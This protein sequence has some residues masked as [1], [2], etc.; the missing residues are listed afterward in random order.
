[1]MAPIATSAACWSCSGRQRPSSTRGSPIRISVVPW[2]RPQAKPMRAALLAFLRFSEAIR[3]VTAARWSGSEA[4]LK[5]SS[6]LT[7]STTHN[8]S[9]PCMKPSSQL[10]IADMALLLTILAPDTQ[11]R[12]GRCRAQPIAST[13]C[14]GIRRLVDDTH[15]LISRSWLNHKRVHLTQI[16]LCYY[17]TVL[18]RGKEVWALK[19]W[20]LVATSRDHAA[21][22]IRRVSSSVC[23]VKGA[24]RGAQVRASGGPAGIQGGLGRLVQRGRSWGSLRREEKGCTYRRY[25]G[26]RDNLCSSR[27]LV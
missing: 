2:P 11:H 3:V 18:G 15:R 16:E 6:R 1:M 27:S 12:P 4:C 21:G 26:A 9:G 17:H 13:V 14:Y 5:P 10:S 7:S 19:G 8:A 23:V 20:D 24:I 25:E 22:V